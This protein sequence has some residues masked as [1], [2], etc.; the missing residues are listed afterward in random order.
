MH[1]PHLMIWIYSWDNWFHPLWIG[2][3]IKP[4]TRLVWRQLE[5]TSN[6]FYQ[7]HKYLFNVISHTTSEE[8]SVCKKTNL[9]LLSR[10]LSRLP[11]NEG[12]T[13][14]TPPPPLG[15]NYCTAHGRT[16]KQHLYSHKEQRETN[17]ARMYHSSQLFNPYTP[18][19]RQPLQ[20]EQ[21]LHFP[22]PAPSIPPSLYIPLIKSFKLFPLS[23]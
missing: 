7:T 13:T 9:L 20:R 2:R 18:T 6:S 16:N 21:S 11:C 15:V 5:K 17:I 19:H 12:V 23:P 10:Y 22:I 14:L 4:S 8:K 1:L 3:S